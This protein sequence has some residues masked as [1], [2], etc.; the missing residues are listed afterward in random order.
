MISDDFLTLLNDFQY[1]IRCLL[2]KKRV[3]HEEYNELLY[4]S[5]FNSTAA[6]F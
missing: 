5:P 4:D 6:C 2:L 3:D 1:I